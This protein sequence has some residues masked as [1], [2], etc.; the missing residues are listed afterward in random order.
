MCIEAP[1]RNSEPRPYTGPRYTPKASSAYLRHADAFEVDFRAS[2]HIGR[3]CS[4][5]SGPI[6]KFLTEWTLTLTYDP[7][8]YGNGTM[9]SD[10]ATQP[11]SAG[12]MR[13]YMFKYNTTLCWLGDEPND[14]YT[15]NFLETTDDVSDSLSH[16]GK[17]YF[18]LMRSDAC[19]FGHIGTEY[20]FQSDITCGDILLVDKIHIKEEFRGLGLSLFMLDIADSTLNGNMSTMMLKPDPFCDDVTGYG[21]AKEKLIR[22]FSMIGLQPMTLPAHRETQDSSN[23]YLGRWNGGRHPDILNVCPHLF[24]QLLA[25]TEF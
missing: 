7:N 24:P 18:K 9:F 23:L 5:E 1:P 6:D 22:H 25:P 20:D 15:R 2:K 17:F 14:Q 19:H 16:F 4:F 21:E 12:T 8:R 10:S 3:G 13:V 11:V